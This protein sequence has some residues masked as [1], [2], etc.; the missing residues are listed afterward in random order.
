M[1]SIQWIILFVAVL[2]FFFLAV[3]AYFCKFADGFTNTN[4]FT[5]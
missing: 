1:N 4:V 5:V 3:V 2:L